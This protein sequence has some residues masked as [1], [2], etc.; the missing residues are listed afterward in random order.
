MIRNLRIEIYTR[1]G[2]RNKLR[3]NRT[4]QNE[5]LYKKQRNKCVALKRKCIKECFPNIADNNI[6]AN[7]RFWNLKR[8]F[9]VN[10]GS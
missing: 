3:Q 5:K 8:S 9:L 4:K 7:K 6:G 10:K 1:N 2:F